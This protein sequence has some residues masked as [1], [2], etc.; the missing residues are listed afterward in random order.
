MNK[1]KIVMV[2][3]LALAMK[4]KAA[5][6]FTNTVVTLSQLTTIL[7]TNTLYVSNLTWSAATTCSSSNTFWAVSNLQYLT[8]SNKVTTNFAVIVPN[9][10][11]NWMRITNGIVTGITNTAP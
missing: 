9:S 5:P 8:F 10:Q 3:V 4:A 7:S 1:W 2:L 6:G 11:T